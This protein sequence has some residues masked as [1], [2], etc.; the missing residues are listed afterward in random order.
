MAQRATL[1]PWCRRPC[2]SPPAGGAACASCSTF[3]ALRIRQRV[4]RDRAIVASVPG[5]VRARISSS[6]LS[7]ADVG[8]G[9]A[10]PSKVRGTSPQVSRL[11]DGERQRC[12]DCQPERPKSMAAG[13]CRRS[14]MGLCRWQSPGVTRCGSRVILAAAIDVGVAMHG[15]SESDVAD[16]SAVRARVPHRSERPAVRLSRKPRRPAIATAGARRLASTV[17]EAHAETPPI[18]VER[19]AAC[20]IRRALIS[21][22]AVD[23]I[24][25]TAARGL[26]RIEPRRSHRKRGLIEARR[27]G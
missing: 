1:R 8:R 18:R 17:S 22:P 16:M 11:P 14:A 27:H 24:W 19:H 25:R 23:E 3:S 10:A 13:C 26:Y 21:A 7:V 5:D 9:R 12:S 6:R 20:T 15:G 4:I 2:S